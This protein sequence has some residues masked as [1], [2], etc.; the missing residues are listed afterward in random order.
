MN[1]RT[2]AN[3]PNAFGHVRCVRGI[4]TERT[5]RDPIGAFV[6][7]VPRDPRR[8]LVPMPGDFW[9][10]GI[11]GRGLPLSLPKKSGGSR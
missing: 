2:E 7:S 10:G 1:S 8:D 5:E 11:G 6:R 3:A 4:Q 9:V